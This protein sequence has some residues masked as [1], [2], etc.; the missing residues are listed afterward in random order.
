MPI[1]KAPGMKGAVSAA[2]T[3]EAVAAAQA[4]V[5]AAPAAAREARTVRKEIAAARAMI[6]PAA[7]VVPPVRA[8]M[9]RVVHVVTGRAEAR[10]EIVVGRAPVRAGRRAHRVRPGHPPRRRWR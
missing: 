5:P 10:V 4:E 1:L 7:L 6:G 8:A 2:M 3:A 9:A